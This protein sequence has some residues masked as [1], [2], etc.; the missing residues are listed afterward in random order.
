MK[1]RAFITLVSGAAVAWPLAAR[2]QQASVPVIGLLNGATPDGYAPYVAAFREGLRRA[3]YVEGQNVAIEYR[4]AQGQYDRLPALAAE[5]VRRQPRV[6]AATSTPICRRRRAN[7]RR[8]AQLRASRSPMQRHPVRPCRARRATPIGGALLLGR[9][10]NLLK[11]SPRRPILARERP[12]VGSMPDSSGDYS[13]P[14]RQICRETRE[15]R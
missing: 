10:G 9:G 1:R 14:A 4:W 13:G 11:P 7:A 5:L 15:P 3:G 2:A 12:A 6:I 8:T